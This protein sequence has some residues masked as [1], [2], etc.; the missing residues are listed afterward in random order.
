MTVAEL[1]EEDA[2]TEYE[3]VVNPIYEEL[4]VD[5]LGKIMNEPDTSKPDLART[6][7]ELMVRGRSR[8]RHSVLLLVYC[9]LLLLSSL[10]L[11]RWCCYCFW[12]RCWFC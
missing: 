9:S 7:G 3:S 12:L 1:S 11:V 2:T 10:L 4:V 6:Y 5:C 8:Q